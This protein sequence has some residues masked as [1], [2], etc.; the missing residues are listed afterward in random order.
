[1]RRS[2]IAVCTE[3][4]EHYAAALALETSSYFCTNVS[5]DVLAAL[6]NTNLLLSRAQRLPLG[7]DELG[8]IGSPNVLEV[9]T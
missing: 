2:S 6:G 3:H 1:M 7:T 9:S 8:G 5:T 4:G